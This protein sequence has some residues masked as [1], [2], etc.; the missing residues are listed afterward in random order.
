MANLRF[1]NTSTAQ[2]ETIKTDAPAHATTHEVGGT[3]VIDVTQLQNYSEQIS[4]PISNLQTS[5]NGISSKQT[6]DESRITT[7]ENNTSNYVPFAGMNKSIDLNNQSLFNGSKEAIKP[8][9]NGAIAFPNQPN[10]LVLPKSSFTSLSANIE[11]TIPF[12]GT[13]FNISGIYTAPVTGSY[14]FSVQ[15]TLNLTNSIAILNIYKNGT[16]LYQLDKFVST[17]SSTIDYVMHGT[18]LLNLNAGDTIKFTATN[19]ASCNTNA[20]HTLC[21]IVKVS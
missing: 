3:D 11:T 14:L 17:T 2:W 13:N 15:L 20:A 1:Y 5:V 7:L 8:Q 4:T 19:S 18:V 12:S 16:F 6:N 9:A 21:S 10:Q